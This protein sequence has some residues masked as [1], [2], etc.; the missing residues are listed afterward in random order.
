M[1]ARWFFVP[2]MVIVLLCNDHNEIAA[3]SLF[4][5]SFPSSNTVDLDS[6]PNT[7]SNT[8]TSSR[9][10]LPPLYGITA[11][12]TGGQHT[13]ALTVSGGVECW[14]ANSYG[15]LGNGTTIDR[16]IPAVV[17]GLGSEMTAITAGWGHTCALTVGGGAKCWG[18]NGAGQL[19]DGTTT[20][21]RTTPVDVT[22][23]NSKIVAITAGM[24]HTCGLT[25][26]GG[27]KCWGDNTWGQLGDGTTTN[28]SMPIDVVGLGSGVIAIA[29]GGYH[30]CALTTDDG[31]KCWG[32]NYY[33]Q[34]GN[35]TMIDRNIVP[36]AVIELEDSITAI[37]A[38]AEHTCALMTSNGIKCWGRNRYGQLGDGTTTNRSTPVSVIGLGSEVIGITASGDPTCGDEGHHTCALMSGG[39]IKC[40]G[41]NGY[42]QLGDGTTIGSNVPV[43]VNGLESNSIA[44]AAGGIHTCA[45]TTEGGVKCW[46]RNEYG[47]LGDGATIQQNKPVDVVG[48]G[49]GMTAITVIGHH[50]CVL[51]SS[52]G[53]KCWGANWSG[54]LGDGTTTERSAP[55][56]VVGLENGVLAIAAGGHHTCALISGGAVKCWGQNR[57]GQLGDGTTI[58]RSLPVDVIG[59]GYGVVA[60]TTGSDHTCALTASGGVKCW[61]DNGFGQRGSGTVPSNGVPVDVIGLDSGIVNISACGSHSCAMTIDGKVKC[62]GYNWAG[63]LGDGTTTNR[64]TPVDVIG[65]GEKVTAITAGWS[66]T[67]AL[68]T[69]GGIKCWGYNRYG[70]LGDG[71]IT[72][73][74]TPVDVISLKIGVDDI[75]AGWRHSCAL[76]IGGEVKCWGYNKTGQLGDGTTIIYRITPV[77]VISLGSGTAAVATG[78]EHTCSLTTGGVVKCWGRNGFGELGLGTYTYRIVPVSVVTP[79]KVFLPL[80]L[81]NFK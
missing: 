16:S 10:L 76:L 61:G 1:K 74:S 57:Y 79:L 46:G 31:V 2:V 45:L 33:G 60:I 14:G 35:G 29:V 20:S 54:Q 51:N 50:T 23:L 19:G 67:C 24:N 40:W 52:G 71:T 34:L 26:G 42:G 69:G 62:W 28:H 70:Q 27:V 64:E 38:G 56:D 48:L 25:A 18:L 53:V 6:F 17:V 58:D 77:N 55:V 9:I 78:A 68:T 81:M 13:C 8:P 4:E 80:V 15:Q 39:G 49:S 63:Q 47:Q 73:R 22:G 12:T 11:V 3:R 66:H 75:K 37:T 59:L 7:D 21:I 30:T 65:L 32:Q 72:N 44:V 41:G 5:L 36:V 43:D